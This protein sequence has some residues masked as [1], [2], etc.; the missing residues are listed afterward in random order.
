MLDNEIRRVSWS[1]W[2]FNKNLNEALKVVK[3]VA[4]G[5]T[6]IISTIRN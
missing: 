6:Q 2:H 4:Q 1:K 3:Q 5:H